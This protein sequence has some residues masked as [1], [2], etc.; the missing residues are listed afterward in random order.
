MK[1]GRDG[2]VLEADPGATRQEA[3]RVLRDTIARPLYDKIKLMDLPAILEYV[4]TI[5]QLRE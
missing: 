5:L 4:A 1:R 2:N 3:L